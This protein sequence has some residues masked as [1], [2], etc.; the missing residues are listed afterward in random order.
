MVER[1]PWRPVGVI[2]GQ[3]TQ[4]RRGADCGCDIE[5][6]DASICCGPGRIRAC[7]TRFRKSSLQMIAES[8]RVRWQ[9]F[10]VFVPARLR[11]CSYESVNASVPLRDLA[12]TRRSGLTLGLLAWAAPTVSH[13]VC[14]RR[15]VSRRGQ[16][17]LRGRGVPRLFAPVAPRW[18]HSRGNCAGLCCGGATPHQRAL[19][20]VIEIESGSHARRPRAARRR[21][22]S[23]SE[24]TTARR[25]M[26]DASW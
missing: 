18:V 23:T 3:Q 15:M 22:T 8:V 14:R 17:S 12:L 21:R 1:G 26:S 10:R 19:F 7:D 6:I 4:S 20:G 13:R 9:T 24:S 11:P 25:I 5:I 2:R 16:N